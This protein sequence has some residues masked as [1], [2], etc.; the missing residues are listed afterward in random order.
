VKVI[1]EALKES[2]PLRQKYRVGANIVR[3]FH[4][5]SRSR[6][7]GQNELEKYEIVHSHANR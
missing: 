1:Y 3:K 6:E 7:E 5:G 2:T 4:L